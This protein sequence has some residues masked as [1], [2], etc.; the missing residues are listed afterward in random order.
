MEFFP[1]VNVYF[2][3][4]LSL[5][6]SKHHGMTK[7]LFNRMRFISSVHPP[8]RK[9]K[10]KNGCTKHNLSHNELGCHSQGKHLENDFC[11]KSGKSQNFVGL[12]RERWKGLEKSGN[13]K[14]WLWLSLGN[15]FFPF[16]VKRC[17]L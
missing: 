12:V 5:S 17:I 1:T 4:I 11:S 16:K 2:S 8:I 6:P 7:I 15:I 13:L 14:T 9:G 3:L 10:G